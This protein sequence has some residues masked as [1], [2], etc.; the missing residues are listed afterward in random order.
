MN[1]S[2][3]NIA[4]CINRLALIGLGVT[5]SSLVRNCA[6]TSKL[7]LNFLCAGLTDDDKNNINELLKL[8]NYKGSVAFMDFEASKAFGSFKSLHGDWTTYGRLLLPELIK[9]KSV[10]YLDADLVV[11]ADVLEV[12]GF[13]FQDMA[14]AVVNSGLIKYTLERKFF[15]E[16]LG[17][18]PST[19]TFNAGVLL[20][21]LDRWREDKLKEKCL[22]F[23]SRYPMELLSCD[24]TILNALFLKFSSLPAHFNCEWLP[25]HQQ[26][27][28]GKKMIF[29]FVGSPKP[30]D[31]LGFLVHNGHLTW[32]SYLNPYW[33]KHYSKLS[34]GDLKRAWKI[35]RSY[36]RVMKLKLKK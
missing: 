36:F 6:Q 35:R 26:P 20:F 13:D 22:A 32:K 25:Y 3:V 19:P 4:F 15:V 21:N 14:L 16:V 9:E 31:I 33:A 1:S 34:L 11:E 2:T 7:K 8:E 12:E 5:I 30:W 29:H 28:T 23:A 24:Q 18:S 17:I 10:L 27:A